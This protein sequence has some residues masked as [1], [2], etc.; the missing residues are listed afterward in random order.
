MN[1][2]STYSNS[3]SSSVKQAWLYFVYYWVV[4]LA[5]TFVGQFV[6]DA[7]RFPITM[8]IFAIIMISL[9]VK[10]SRKFD[11]LLSNVL[12]FLL[13]VVSYT[14]FTYYIADLGAMSFY[15]NIG[16]AVGSFFA[17]GFL[18]Y[19]VVGDA[20]NLGRL[21]FPA[22]IVL[23]L[24]SFAGLFIHIPMFQLVLTIAGLAIFLLYTIYDF[25]RMKR[26]N[27]SAR[28]MG[29]NL[30]INLLNIIMDVLRLAS[31]LKD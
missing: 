20:T 9:F 27:F 3:R 26:G 16:L 31:I 30:F 14:A 11:S 21:L 2:Q 19:F 13:G 29:F 23:V 24:A 8:L 22:L 12:A 6:P 4:F 15:Q 7:L 28:E 17:F 5:G 18:G 25:N 10:A 1:Y